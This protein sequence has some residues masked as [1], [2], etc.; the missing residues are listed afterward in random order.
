MFLNLMRTNMCGFRKFLTVQM[1]GGGSYHKTF[2]LILFKIDQ[3]LNHVQY[4]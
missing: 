2:K 1:Y 3:D 4:T